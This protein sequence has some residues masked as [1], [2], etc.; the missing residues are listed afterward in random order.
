MVYDG[1]GGDTFH[2]VMGG[3]LYRKKWL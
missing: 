3:E 2:I 1:T